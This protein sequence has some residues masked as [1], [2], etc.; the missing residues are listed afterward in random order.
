MNFKKF[1]G[2]DKVSAKT[3]EFLI[4]LKLNNVYWYAVLLDA[5]GRG[6]VFVKK[7][8]DE[9]YKLRKEP[10]LFDF[11][12]RGLSIFEI[13]LYVR[14]YKAQLND[15]PQDIWEATRARRARVLVKAMKK[16]GLFKPT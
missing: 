10:T 5:V 9:L 8:I 13:C 16:D 6:P 1:D 14:Q 7:V 11:D 15:L 4:R 3:L 12:R 2:I